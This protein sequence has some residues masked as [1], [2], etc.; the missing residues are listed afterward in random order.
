MFVD[1][2]L[3]QGQKDVVQQS[4]K[5]RTVF[6]IANKMKKSSCISCRGSFQVVDE[7]LIL[8]NIALRFVERNSLL[9]G[10]MPLY[11]ETFPRR[12]EELAQFFDVVA[13]AVVILSNKSEQESSDPGIAFAQVAN[14]RLKIQNWMVRVAYCKVLMALL[15]S[16]MSLSTTLVGLGARGGL[17]GIISLK[18]RLDS[19]G[20]R[21]HVS[22]WCCL[23][24]DLAKC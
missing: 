22:A 10:N 19:T 18:T 7:S 1:L 24:L 4:R 14:Q 2:T 8:Q 23:L 13:T 16:E 15:S 5:F 17:S 11:I 3:L 6:E 12:C 9:F 20:R 21:G